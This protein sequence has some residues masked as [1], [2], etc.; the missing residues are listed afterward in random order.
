MIYSKI[1]LTG[2]IIH[3]RICKYRKGMLGTFETVY[4]YLLVL[5]RSTIS[6][7]PRE[8]VKILDCE[9]HPE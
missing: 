5:Y 4:K 3:L 8:L 6:E 1:F 7:L 9:A 2:L